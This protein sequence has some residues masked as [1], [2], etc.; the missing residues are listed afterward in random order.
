MKNQELLNSLNSYYLKGDYQKVSDLLKN[1]GK[2][3]PSSIWNYNQGVMYYKMGNLPMARWYW[4][5]SRWSD[6]NFT[7]VENNLTIVKEQLGIINIETAANPILREYFDDV[8]LKSDLLVLSSSIL[9][10]VL[11][12]VVKGKILRPIW[13]YGCFAVILIPAIYLTQLIFERSSLGVSN[14]AIIVK[15]S[16]LREGPSQ[17]FTETGK[18]PSGLKV[19][20]G[21][22]QEKW[23]LISSPEEFYGWVDIEDLKM[24]TTS[25]N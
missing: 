12:W 25:K 24:I 22:Q 17:I 9:L 15:E 2:S 21:E 20:L 10:L 5:K 23:A 1:E 8:G 7:G 3:F 14:K 13:R 4:E 11:L 16:T 19:T 18:I 6:F